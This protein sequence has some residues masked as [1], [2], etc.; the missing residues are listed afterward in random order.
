MT[1]GETESFPMNEARR[2]L[3]SRLDY[4]LTPRARDKEEGRVDDRL[5]IAAK[6]DG[7]RVRDPTPKEQIAHE[8]ESRLQ[9]CSKKNSR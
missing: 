5:Q 7:R 9:G 2:N 3:A 8:L 6:V 4:R 1:T